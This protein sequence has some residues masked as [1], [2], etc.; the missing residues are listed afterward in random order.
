MSSNNRFNTYEDIEDFRRTRWHLNRQI[1]KL[2]AEIKTLP[3]VSAVENMNFLEEQDENTNIL[4]KNLE[5]TAIL[6]EFEAM[7][8]ACRLR[9][10]CIV[11]KT[12]LNRNTFSN[13]EMVKGV[14]NKIYYKQKAQR[15]EAVLA[16]LCYLK[17]IG[18]SY[19]L[20]PYE[21]LLEEVKAVKKHPP[22][23]IVTENL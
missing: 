1:D 8:Y 19:S 17:L 11:L 10:I 7:S 5:H 4:A 12:D 23:I 22:K 15:I 20:I 3:D 13:F 14:I 16:V 2:Y 6:S 18:C 21:E 9:D